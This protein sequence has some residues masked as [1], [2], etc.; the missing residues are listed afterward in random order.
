MR[1]KA[2][3]FDG[4]GVLRARKIKRGLDADGQSLAAIVQTHAHADHY[5]GNAYLLQCYPEA[6]VYAPPVEEAVMR[7][8]L[9]EPIYLNM[10][11]APVIPS[12]V[13]NGCW[14]RI[15][16]VTCQGT[17]RMSSRPMRLLRTI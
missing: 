16:P 11:A 9:L 2:G 12:A 3:E 10:G 1:E 15:L 6:E 7:Y 14:P 13:S 5:G 8:P 4:H 17:G